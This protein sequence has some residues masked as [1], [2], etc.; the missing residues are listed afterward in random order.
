MDATAHRELQR[1]NND[2]RFA[3]S[4]LTAQVEIQEHL[5]LFHE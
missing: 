5:L 3:V 4:S 1:N 2:V